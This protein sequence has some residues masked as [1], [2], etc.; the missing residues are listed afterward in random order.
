M[1]FQRK[2]IRIKLQSALSSLEFLYGILAISSWK[3]TLSSSHVDVGKRGKVICSL[4]GDSNNSIALEPAIPV[5]RVGILKMYQR[6]V[7]SLDG[8]WS[9]GRG[10]G[11][12][13]DPQTLHSWQANVCIPPTTGSCPLKGLMHQILHSH[14]LAD[15]LNLIFFSIS[16]IF[17]RKR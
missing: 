4:S 13:S 12:L 5:D 9:L 2:F 3:H 10:P 7:V 11:F 8:P 16:P 1:Y 14:N 15:F 6:A 17:Q